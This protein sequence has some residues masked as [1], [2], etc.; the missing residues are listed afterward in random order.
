MG[1]DISYYPIKEQEIQEWYFEI[2]SDNS[3]IEKL[4]I[5][6]GI[7]DFYKQKYYDTIEV[8]N[9]TEP[10]DFFDKTHGHYITVVQGFFR[11][12]YYTRGSAFSFLI[13]EKPHFKNYTKGWQDFLN[14][15]IENPIKNKITD[16]YS[17]GVYIPAEKVVDLLN[18][19]KTNEKILTRIR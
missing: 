16:N 12:Y 1:F 7:E 18:D 11:T 13:E 3:K 9:K 6:N 8:G 5:D 15:K 17:S 10:A 2:L 19:Y 14:F 4:S